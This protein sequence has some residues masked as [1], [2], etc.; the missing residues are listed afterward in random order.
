MRTRSAFPL[1]FRSPPVAPIQAVWGSFAAICMSFVAV[2]ALAFLV[3]GLWRMGG[4]PRG[5]WADILGV[6]AISFF[7][8]IPIAVLL[9]VPVAALVFF[10]KG[11]LLSV[12]TICA[13]YSMGVV[14]TAFDTPWERGWTLVRAA[15]FLWPYPLLSWLFFWGAFTRP[16]QGKDGG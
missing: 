9:T 6:Y 2:A 3:Y 8:G 10:Q 16:Q 1:Y 13:L 4:T 5:E 14:W 7:F 11:G 15:T 12:I